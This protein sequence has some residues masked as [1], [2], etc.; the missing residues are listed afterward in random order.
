MPTLIEVTLLITKNAHALTGFEYLVENGATA[1]AAVSIDLPRPCI[2]IH[3]A[4]KDGP[5]WLTQTLILWRSQDVLSLCRDV[6]ANKLRKIWSIAMLRAGNGTNE[7]ELSLTPIKEIRIA[8]FGL[9]GLALAVYITAA[10]DRIDERGRACSSRA[11][12]D[13][14]KLWHAR[15]PRK[16]S[17]T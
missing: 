11:R 12:T 2:L 14:E 8:D 15:R 3:Y 9:T 4:E 16:R 13:V 7:H 10:G 1:W 17:A 5:A 6:K